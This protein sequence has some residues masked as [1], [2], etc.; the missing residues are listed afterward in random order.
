VTQPTLSPDDVHVVTARE[1][2]VVARAVRTL[3][4]E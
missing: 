3:V 4:G 2:A 1:D